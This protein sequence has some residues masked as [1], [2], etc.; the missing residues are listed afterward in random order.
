MLPL[1]IANRFVPVRRY[2]REQDDTP[3][4]KRI[5]ADEEQEHQ[6][7]LKELQ[8]VG[9]GAVTAGKHPKPSQKKLLNQTKDD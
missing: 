6:L 7:M 9:E 8:T 3:S 1:R 2:F 4:Q 5:E